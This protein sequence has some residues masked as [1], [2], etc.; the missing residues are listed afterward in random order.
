MNIFKGYILVHLVLFLT[1]CQ[2]ANAGHIYSWDIDIE[3]QNVGYARKFR[4]FFSLESGLS[5]DG[6]I[7]IVSPLSWGAGN[8]VNA[9]LYPMGSKRVNIGNY[10]NIY[11]MAI[12]YQKKIRLARA[13]GFL[14]RKSESPSF[15]R[16]EKSLN[17]FHLI[18]EL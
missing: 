15:L 14:G 7:N 13:V 2:L 5:K 16:R 10:F 18:S 17:K 3:K 11:L 4:L 9:T 12:K 1:L 8:M 6:F